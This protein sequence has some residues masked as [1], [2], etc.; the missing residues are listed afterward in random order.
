MWKKRRD[1]AEVQAARPAHLPLVE[2]PL[3]TNPGVAGFWCD[4]RG[5]KADLATPHLAALT[6]HVPV[7]G[8]VVDCVEK[9]DVEGPDYHLCL[10]YELN[11]CAHQFFRVVGYDSYHWAVTDPEQFRWFHD[12]IR[13]GSHL[14][15]LVDPK[16][17][18]KGVIFGLLNLYWNEN[19]TVRW[20]AEG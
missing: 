7:K 20:V 8:W 16:D 19:G 2:A 6:S 15:L 11:G 4:R 12:H 18:G 13:K 10:A 1:P 9:S 5:M 3:R 17:P 14:T